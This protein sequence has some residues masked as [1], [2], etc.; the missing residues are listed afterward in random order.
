[1]LNLVPLYGVPGIEEIE[2]NV[3]GSENDLVSETE[4]EIEKIED[5][6]LDAASDTVIGN[7]NWEGSNIY[8]YCTSAGT[9]V[10]EWKFF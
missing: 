6:L 1:M 5:L 3:A 4:D 8:V 10:T 9:F 7:A 2:D